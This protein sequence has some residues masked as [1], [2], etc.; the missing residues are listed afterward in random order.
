MRILLPMDEDEEHARA[1]VDAVRSLPDAANAVSVTILNVQQ[2][3]DVTGGEGGRVSS[4][5]WYDD[6]EFP[7]S[8]QN[9]E[10]LLS[11]AGITVEKQRK[12]ADVAEAIVET[13]EEMDADRII[14]AG[15]RR[16]PVGKVVFGSTVQK[17]IQNTNTPVTFVPS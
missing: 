17:V 13:A 8:V 14:M 15:R 4:N 3:I 12:H 7:E 1:A 2:K 5:D 9:A 16:S 6:D 11:D 10:A